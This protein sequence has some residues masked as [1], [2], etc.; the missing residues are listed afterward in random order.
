[1]ATCRLANLNLDAS[2]VSLLSSHHFLLHKDI[3]CLSPLELSESLDI[4]VARAERLLAR[5]AEA[6]MNSPLTAWSLY[7]RDNERNKESFSSA[8]N[9]S[10]SPRFLSLRALP[11]TLTEIVGPAG[12][13]K[14]QTCFTLAVLSVMAGHAVIFVDTEGKFSLSRFREMLCAR[15]V[16]ESGERIEHLMAYLKVIE[17]SSTAALL[18]ELQGMEDAIIKYGVRLLIIDSIAAPV[19]REFDRERFNEKQECLSKIASLLKYL[20]ETFSLSCV[21]TNQVTTRFGQS[22]D[23][24]SFQAA[25]GVAWAH[26]IN[27]RFVVE[28]GVEPG[29]RVI[30]V[31]KSPMFAQTAFEYLVTEAGVIVER[32]LEA[33]PDARSVDVLTLGIRKNNNAGGDAPVSFL[34]HYYQRENPSA[35]LHD[36]EQESIFY[37]A[38]EENYT[39]EESA[40]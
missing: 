21:V 18:T 4:S 24:S 17:A 37:Q 14:T 22:N 3:A 7:E 39:D 35:A 31:A 29:S 13:G 2:D 15:Y 8:S 1:M 10:L 23:S 40:Q 34:E 16:C 30:V 32:E 27:T 12:L 19:R 11:G 28:D 26:A 25:L 36:A 33:S 5:A 20:S 9:L 38:I 6:V